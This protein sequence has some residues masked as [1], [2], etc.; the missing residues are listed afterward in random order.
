LSCNQ[1]ACKG[2]AKNKVLTL[3]KGLFGGPTYYGQ[4]PEGNWDGA[5]VILEL[6]DW[7]REVPLHLADKKHEAILVFYKC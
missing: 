7:K 3:K 6:S 4:K 1:K 5:L 2:K